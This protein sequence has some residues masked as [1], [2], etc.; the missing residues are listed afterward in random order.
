MPEYNVIVN[1]GEWGFADCERERK[2]FAYLSFVS[3]NLSLFFSLVVADT[4]C[5][6]DEQIRARRANDAAKYFESSRRTFHGNT[7][8]ESMH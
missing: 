1:R 4:I 7:L 6:L 5:K 3:D 8:A 2:K